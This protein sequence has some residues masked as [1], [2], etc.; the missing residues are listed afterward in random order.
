MGLTDFGE[1]WKINKERNLL[2]IVMISYY[3]GNTIE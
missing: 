2:S 3:G 1:T